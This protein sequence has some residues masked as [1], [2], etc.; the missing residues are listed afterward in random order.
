MRVVF[1]VYDLASRQVNVPPSPTEES[2]PPARLLN[3]PNGHE[4]FRQF[5]SHVVNSAHITHLL[6]NW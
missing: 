2:E 1:G 3:A 6:L 5:A 4:E